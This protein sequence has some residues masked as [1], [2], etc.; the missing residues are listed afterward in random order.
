[1]ASMTRGRLWGP[2]LTQTTRV[3]A[4]CAPPDG[5]IT[6]F[7]PTGS[8]YTSASA[9][10]LEGDVTGW[11]QDASLVVHGFLRSR[12]G[13]FTSFDVPGSMYQ[14][15]PNAI[16]AAGAITG[17]FQ[18]ASGLHGFVRANDGT[19]TTFDPPGS[20]DPTPILW[21]MASTRRG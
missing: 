18:E 10:N 2:T 19:F 12:H 1:M 3:T 20:E 9:I 14:T 16:D 13:T 5:T 7:D 4:S 8:I 6:P 15:Q 21:R 17:F 11:W